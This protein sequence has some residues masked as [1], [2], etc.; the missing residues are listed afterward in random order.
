VHVVDDAERARPLAVMRWTTAADDSDRA[1]LDACV[2]PTLDVGCGPGRMT[3]G[4]AERGTVA[5]GI[6]VVAEAVAQTRARGATALRRDVFADVPGHGRW[7]TVLL[8]DGNIGIGGDPL[9]LLRRACE[10]L[11]PGGRVVVDL[12]APGRRD[13]VRRCRLSSDGRVSHTFLWAVAGVDAIADLAA[14]AG[15]SLVHTSEHDGRWF[16]V[17]GKAA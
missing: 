14:A 3:S 17:L 5:L 15:L 4:L 1:L 11:A 16:A 7:R 2:G 10:L 13:V 6:D 12:A 9:R 8:A